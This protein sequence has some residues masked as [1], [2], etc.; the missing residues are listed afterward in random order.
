MHIQKNIFLKLYS[1]KHFTVKIIKSMITEVYIYIKK[2]K[3]TFKITFSCLIQ[4]YCFVITVKVDFFL[5]SLL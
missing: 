1:R 2:K 4:C 3:Q 5:A